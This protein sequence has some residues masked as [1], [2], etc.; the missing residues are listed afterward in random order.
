MIKNK[1]PIVCCLA[2]L[3]L[4]NACGVNSSIMFKAPK[5]ESVIVDS[6]PMYPVGDYRI[7]V[8]DKLSFTLATNNGATILESM[9]GLSPDVNKN[10][11]PSDYVVRSNGKVEI[12]VIGEVQAENLTIAQFEDTLENLFSKA[13][14]NPFVQVKVTNQRVIIFPGGGGD[15][16]VIVLANNNTTLMEVIAAAGGIAERGKANTVKLIRKENGTRKIY[17]LDLSTVQGLK[18]VDM[19]VQANDYIYIEPNDDI[20]KE[21]IKDIAPIVA[22]L[23]NLVI[24]FTLITK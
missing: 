5:G 24:L 8:D 13:Y 17:H 10:S 1:I 2:L 20:A 7:S 21:T 22:V 19:I 18:Y 9:S 4:L 15:A 14:K 6:I 23:S 12:P 3:Y 16:K 11:G